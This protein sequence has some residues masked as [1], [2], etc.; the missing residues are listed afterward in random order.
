MRRSGFLAVGVLALAA[1]QAEAAGPNGVRLTYQGDPAT[2]VAVSWNSD[3]PA[4]ATVSFGTDPAALGGTAEATRID[5]PSPLRHSF[6]AVLTGLDPDTTY[7]YRVAGYPAED[8]E[9]LSFKTAPADPCAPMRFVLMGDNRQDIGNASNPVWEGVLAEAV[10]HQPLFFV[11]TGDMVESGTDPTQWSN[12]I[13]ASEPGF[14][15]VPSILTMGNHDAD[16]VDGDGAIYNQLYALPENATTGTEDYY[17]IDVGPIHFVS[18]NTQ[19]DQ[20]GS[21]EWNE[22]LEWLDADLGASHQPWTMVFFHKA[23]YSRGNHSSGEENEGEINK[24]L[25]PIFDAHQVD[26]VL[27]GHS[28]DYERYAPSRG[29]DEEFGGTGRSFTAGMGSE[30]GEVIPDGTVGTTYIVAGGAGAMTTDI[31]GLDIHCLDAACTLCTP[32]Y[33]SCPEEVY[34]NDVNGTVVYDGRHNFAVFDVTGGHIQVEVYTTQAGNFDQ[35]ELIDRFEVDT[36][37]SMECGDDGDGGDSAGHDGGPGGDEGDGA[38]GGGDGAGCACRAAG[39]SPGG[40]VLLALGFLL[41][42]R[43]RII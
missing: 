16:E 13:K 32:F 36:A 9:P 10:D 29:V 20:P 35:P 12:F 17:S 6:T 38:S 21:S 40:I 27:N 8:A 33:N 7:Y 39:S 22:M 31:P 24:S 42:R 2:Q 23:V 26:F 1:G 3:D 37:A 41:L 30:M 34:D 25:V 18:L 14:A 19:F 28:H 4:D 43:R 11:N 5:Q 15:H